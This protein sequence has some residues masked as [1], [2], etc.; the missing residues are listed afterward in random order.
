MVKITDVAK[1][2]GVSPSTVSHVLNGNRPISQKTKDHVMAVI[3]RL[4][5]QKNANAS[6]LK[7]KYSGIIGFFA[8][9][10]TELFVTRIIKGVENI[11][12][13][14]GIHL[15][16]A[17]SAEFG[18]DLD[19]TL[20]FLKKRNIDGIII[21]YGITQNTEETELNS[22]HLPMVTINRNIS[23][24]ITSVLPD[25][26]DGGY[27][28][29]RHLIERGAV[30]LAMIAGP[31]NRMA[32]QRRRD[33]FLEGIKDSELLSYQPLVVYGEFDFKS[34]YRLAGEILENDP[35]VDGIFCA[36]DYMAAGAIDYAR[37]HGIEI[38]EQL[39]VIGFDNREFSEFWPTP[40]TTFSQPLESMGEK[41]A[42]LLMDLIHRKGIAREK[43]YMKS[44]LIERKS[45]VP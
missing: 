21:S 16:F 45:T 6:A 37:R 22:L 9:D 24:S 1:E 35:S 33:G 4:G 31:K 39:K 29:A 8:S 36:N 3:D 42:E 23:K 38:P 43:I 32:S 27:S 26:F 30:H 40:I 15:V 10:I 17:S 34:G 19:K 12:R 7:S 5:Y 25:N 14:R 18:Y 41:S 11:T 20:T 2:A 28:A 13:E 44:T